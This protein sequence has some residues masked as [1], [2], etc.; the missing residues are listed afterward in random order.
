MSRSERTSVKTSCLAEPY[1]E[2]R[3]SLHACLLS[4]RPRNK[5]RTEKRVMNL[6]M[7]KNGMDD[8]CTDVDKLKENITNNNEPTILESKTS[9]PKKFSDGSNG[10]VITVQPPK[11]SNDI[12][13]RRQRRSS[14]V[15]DSIGMSIPVS[16]NR[17]GSVDGFLTG[18]SPSDRGYSSSPSSPHSPIKPPDHRRRRLADTIDAAC[19]TQPQPIPDSDEPVGLPTVEAWMPVERDS[20]EYNMN[21]PRRGHAVIFNNEEFEMLDMSKRVGSDADVKNLE[22][23]YTALG[24]DIM[25]YHNKNCHEIKKIIDNLAEQDHSDADCMIVTVLSHGM[26]TGFILAKD[27]PYKVESL[28]A[29]FTADKCPTLAGKPKIF[30]IQACRG[31]SLDPGV[32]L[33]RRRSRTETDSGSESYKIPTHADFLLAFSSVEGFYSFR[34]PES[35]TWFVQCLCEELT[36]N[37]HKHDLLKLLTRTARRVALDYESY[38]D[39]IPWQHRQKQ[40]PTITSMLIREVYFRP[41]Q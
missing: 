17:R 6:E 37:A 14:D 27:Y 32:N 11:S 30:F 22:R 18:T 38:N 2:D 31:E 41:K 5:Q 13:R 20:E 19:T 15:I 34:N 25:I 21:H 4:E 28:W 33:T 16:P 1:A 24:F 10:P 39:I 8:N 36:Q 3:Q 35:G 40:V 29:P 23:L 26:G 7:D 12:P 9:F